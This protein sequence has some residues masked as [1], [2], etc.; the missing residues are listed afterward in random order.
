MNI[1]YSINGVPIR[2]TEERWFHIVESHNDLA[3]RYDDILATVESPDLILRGH[4]GALIAVRGMGRNRYLAV[5]Y[6]ELSPDDGFI[7]SAYFTSKIDR[8]KVLWRSS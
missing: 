8:R 3:G 6:R 1:A 5:V 4:R 2:L 7:I